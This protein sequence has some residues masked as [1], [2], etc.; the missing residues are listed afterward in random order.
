MV[1]LFP[2]L[3]YIISWTASDTEAMLL[4]AGHLIS[5]LTPLFQPILGIGLVGIVIT[6]IIYAIKH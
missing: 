2:I 6:A 5:D 4:V 3:F 1:F